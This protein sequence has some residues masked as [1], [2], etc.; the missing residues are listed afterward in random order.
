MRAAGLP[1]NFRRKTSAMKLPKLDQPDNYQGLYVFDFGE[2]CAVGYTADEITVLV[3]SEEY[4]I[5]KVYR[6]VRATPDGQLELK[7]VSRNRFELESGMLFFRGTSDDAERDF[8]DLLDRADDIAP[9]TRCFVH[10]TDRGADAEYGRFI[11][12]LIYPAE[13][14]DDMAQWL[15]KLDYAGGDT[16][17]AGP[18]CVSNY[19]EEAHTILRKEQLWSR[20]A[21]ASRSAAEILRDV[22]IPVQRRA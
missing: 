21:H 11:T 7:G 5:G 17:E 2:W 3:E 4:A 14:E 6:I 19:Y 20:S 22:R 1:P 18:S 9:P 13:F 12:A 8:S 15:L 10:L 16:V